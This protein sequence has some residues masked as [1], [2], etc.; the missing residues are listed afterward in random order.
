MLRWIVAGSLFAL[1]ATGHAQVKGGVTC[2]KGKVEPKSIG[3]YYVPEKKAL[4]IFFYTQAVTD[5]EMDAI[6]AKAAEFNLGRPAKGPGAGAKNKYVKYAFK[7]WTSADPKTGGFTE[8]D[9]GSGTYFSFVCDTEKVPD[10]P[11]KERAAKVKAA[12]PT[13]SVELKQGGKVSVASTGS[14]TGK[15]GDKYDVTASWDV[16]GV[17][18]VRVY[19]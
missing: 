16:Q 19:E 4:T 6:L 8:K 7:A 11:F 5:E 12:F 15:P 9:V 18:K 10:I 13:F 17:G 3:A 2:P 1:C 14:H